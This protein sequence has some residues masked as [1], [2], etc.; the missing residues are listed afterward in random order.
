M[1][2]TGLEVRLREG[3]QRAE[4]SQFTKTLDEIVLSLREIDKV[5][6]RRGT[7]ATWVL[8]DLSHDK[9]DLVVRLEARP[10]PRSRPTED[11]LVPVS[12]FVSGAEHLAEVAEVP[13]LF[14]PST[15]ERV[16][17]IAR[18]D[19]GVERVS[20]ATYNGQ[21]GR[22]VELGDDVVA[23]AK[24]A[25]RPHETSYGT[26]TGVLDAVAVAHRRSD[27]K[28]TIFSETD[29]QAV[30]GYAPEGFA[31]ELRMLWRHRV[32]IGGRVKRNQRGQVLRIE[33]NRIE[34]MP[35]DNAGRPHIERLIGAAPRWLGGQSVDEYLRGVRGA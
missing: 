34:R 18:P 19:S 29:R 25:V 1:G 28:V 24:E 20:V 27:V 31:E 15:V 11:M 10:S 32:V 6:L 2:T 9:E 17:R 14:M 12:A 30:E 3:R 26:V 35:E 33:V 23:H 21:R 7:R 13:R 4:V 8:A 22:L 5:Y 16:L